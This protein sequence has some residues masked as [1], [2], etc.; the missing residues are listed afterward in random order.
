MSVPIPSLITDII[1][2]YAWRPALVIGGG[3]SVL[4]DIPALGDWEPHLVLSANQHGHF[5]TRYRVT[6]MVNVDKIH[7]R[8][9][10]PMRE[11]LRQWPGRIINKFTWAD[12]RLPDWPYGGN[13][14][15]TA[16]AVAA[17][18]GC[19]PIVVTGL[20]LHWAMDNPYFHRFVETRK[21][22]NI[23]RRAPN[24]PF[25]VD[26]RTRSK[27]LAKWVEG[28]NVRPLSGPLLDQFPRFDRDEALP[29]RTDTPYR[30]KLRSIPTHR[31]RVL[32]PFQ[33]EH[34]DVTWRGQLIAMTERE[35]QKYVGRG[36]CE[37]Y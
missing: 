5:Q 12:Y 3:P 26:Q 27:V 35:A 14:G 31:V 17:A 25:T 4:K 32:R 15:L 28:S 7:T 2:R 33:F 13:S 29:K 21:K 16:V 8:A 19:D 36:D 11:Y 10:V 23:V 20:D 18:L 22:T 9:Q 37:P 24:P 30:A 34:R 1:D 6:F